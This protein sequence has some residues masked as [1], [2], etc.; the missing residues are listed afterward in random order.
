[1]CH[2]CTG[3]VSES[4]EVELQAVKNSLMWMLGLISL[5]RKATSALN[6]SVGHVSSPQINHQTTETYR[7]HAQNWV[8]SNNKNVFSGSGGQVWACRAVL[9]PKQPRDDPSC[10]FQLFQVI[11]RLASLQ[12]LCLFTCFSWLPLSHSPTG[13]GSILMI[14]STI[15]TR[16]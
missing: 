15:S 3:L 11:L 13:L 16:I 8:A 14:L 7:E 1:M 5:E 10:V 2:M 12:P 6:R 9:P 4:L